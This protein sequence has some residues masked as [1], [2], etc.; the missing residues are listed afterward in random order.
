MKFRM[1]TDL[2]PW[3]TERLMVSL[4]R[5][6][7]Y[8]VGIFILMLPSL[9]LSGITG[10]P[11]HPRQGEIHSLITFAVLELCVWFT[12]I[13]HWRELRRRQRKL[14]ADSN[15]ASHGTLARSSP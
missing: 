1:F 5:Q 3:T 9:F 10:E 7:A 4:R 12:F 14:E 6:F 15:T 13:R 11:R 2:A 8:S